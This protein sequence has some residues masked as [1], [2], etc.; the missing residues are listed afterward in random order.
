MLTKY[1]TPVIS[2]LSKERGL[3]LPNLYYTVPAEDRLRAS[4]FDYFKSKN[5]NVVAI[6]SAKKTTSKDFIIA[7]KDEII[8]NTN[9]VAQDIVILQSLLTQ[10]NLIALENLY[11]SVNSFL[12][13][14]PQIKELATTILADNIISPLEL[15][16]LNPILL[17]QIEGLRVQLKSIVDSNSTVLDLYNQ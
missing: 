6:I 3:P 13:A 12:D 8:A 4:M 17:A 14:N 1:N 2:P 5:G 11:H 15:V 16:T 9:L 10:E 7:N